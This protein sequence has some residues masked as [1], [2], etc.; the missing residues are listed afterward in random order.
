[1]SDS[2]STEK[3]Y[4]YPT[5][6]TDRV[7]RWLDKKGPADWYYFLPM[8]V[9][10]LLLLPLGWDG[11][12]FPVRLAQLLGVGALLIWT[13]PRLTKIERTK[14][15][16]LIGIFIGLVGLVQWIGMDKALRSVSWLSW[17]YYGYG[18]GDEDAFM[19]D[20]WTAATL[21]VVII[22]RMA[23]SSIV[24]PVMEEIFW[25]DFLW[26]TLASPNDM[27]KQGV[28]EYDHIAF[29]GTAVAF[30]TV[31]PQWLV[32]IGY[33]LLMSWLIWKTKSLW[34]VIVAHAVTNFTLWLY[35]L[36]AWYG[37]GKDEWYFW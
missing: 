25:R 32:A 15:H 28:G 9:F 5:Q 20:I 34:S 35:V 37:F 8:A 10:L 13:W 2:A 31:H 11:W 7:Q 16:T 1:M 27:H 26:R 23:I 24:V 3:P 12:D 29:F 6:P 22:V 4:P 30:A 14:S 19:P 36:I 21:P 33:G 18:P 17:T